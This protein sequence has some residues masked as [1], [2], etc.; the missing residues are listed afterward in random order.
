MQKEI[1]ITNL[2]KEDL[3]AIVDI[4]ERLSGIHRPDDWAK[5]IEMS[6]AYDRTG[7]PWSPRPAERLWDSR[8]RAAG[9]W[10]R[11]RASRAIR[12]VS[13]GSR[14]YRGFHAGQE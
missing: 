3:P 2:S 10:H 7:R 8:S 1:Y 14:H 13:G 6:E 4:E 9:S 11:S 12:R 5:R